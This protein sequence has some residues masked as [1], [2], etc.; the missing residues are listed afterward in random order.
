MMIISCIIGYLLKGLIFASVLFYRWKK[1]TL[2]TIIPWDWKHGI[3]YALLWLPILIII[4]GLSLI[5]LIR[6]IDTWKK[7]KSI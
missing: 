7:I 1:D 2:N 6:K 3:L 4:I 5:N